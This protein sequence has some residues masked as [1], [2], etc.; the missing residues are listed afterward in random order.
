MI[1]EIIKLKIFG[2]NIPEIAKMLNVSISSI[3][4]RIKKVK[5]YLNK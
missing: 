4:R 5:K 3:Y 2:Y 1:L